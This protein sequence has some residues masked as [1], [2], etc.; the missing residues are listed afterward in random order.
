MKRLMHILAVLGMLRFVMFVP[1]P[2]FA[3]EW[4]AA[5]KE[6]WKNVVAYWELETKQDL[7]GFM[8]YFHDDYR[9]WSYERALPGDKATVRKFVAVSFQTTKRLA[10]DIK[11]AAIQIHGSIAFV[12]YY[13]NETVKDAEGKVKDYSGRWTDIL[14]RQG[15]RWVLIG[16]HGGRTSKD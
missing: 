15:D 13:F 16:D 7:D 6:I 9:G 1:T 8:S 11:P 5:Q 12:H 2:L 3:Q 4:S 14:M 10:Y